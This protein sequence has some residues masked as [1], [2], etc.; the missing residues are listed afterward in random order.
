[1]KIAFPRCALFA[2]SVVS[3]I[4]PQLVSAQKQSAPATK[5]FELTVDSIMRGPRLVGYPPAGVYWSQDSQRVYFR[6]KQPDEP[7]LKEMSLY[8]VNRDGT[9]LR[10]LTD[11]EA[12][13]AP[14][15]NGELSKD[16]TMTV[17]TDEGDVFIYDHAKGSRRQITKTVDAET[18]AHFTFDQKHIYFTRLNNLYVM[19]L[20]GGSLE[21]L[22]DIRV[23]GGAPAASAS[24]PKGTESQEYLKKE[25]RALLDAVRERAEQREEQEQ[26]RKEREKRKPFNIPTGQNVIK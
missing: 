3:L 17:F 18:N 16:K 7:R 25:E 14:P 11:E 12:K 24:P 19:S 4:V 13:Q 26:K 8:V 21:Q 15:A 9:G 5:P 23:G 20:D 1:M 6:W 2:L 22:T 10:R